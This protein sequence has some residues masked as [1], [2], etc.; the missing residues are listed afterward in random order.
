MNVD[1]AEIIKQILA[2]QGSDKEVKRALTKAV[3]MQFVEELKN[4][5]E[6]ERPFTKAYLAQKLHE[7][8]HFDLALCNKTLDTLCTAL[9]TE[10]IPATLPEVVP[11]PQSVKR[12]A[13]KPTN[14]KM[15]RRTTAKGIY[16]LA[17]IIL[18]LLIVIGAGVLYL[19]LHKKQE[20]LIEQEIQTEQ[21]KPDEDTQEDQT[22][23]MDI[24]EQENQYE[25]STEQESTTDQEAQIEHEV[26]LE[27]TNSGGD[28]NE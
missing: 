25:M 12:L 4:T 8:G 21:I 3:K 28:E 1:L 7:E 5:S 23:Q 24:E 13:M 22:D 18:T 20:V 10:Q 27:Q 14:K 26:Q 19:V 17:I 6:K 2:D 15:P 9:F 11:Q 16:I